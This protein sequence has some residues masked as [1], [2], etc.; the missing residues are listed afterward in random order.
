MVVLL[1]DP[2]GPDINI[3]FCFHQRAGPEP[4]QIGQNLPLYFLSILD[5]LPEEEG[6]FIQ[7][8]T[9]GH[10]PDNL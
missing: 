10:Q 1:P 8:R 9:K 4:V 3:R 2:A 5:A 6:Y 7:R